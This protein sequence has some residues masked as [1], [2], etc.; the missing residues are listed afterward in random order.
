MK[1]LA[2]G[3]HVIENKRTIQSILYTH[4]MTPK[5]KDLNLQIHQI[6]RLLL[7]QHNAHCIKVLRNSKLDR[8]AQPSYNCLAMIGHV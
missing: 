3:A 1:L 4:I 2:F 6:H 5:T 7:L 8:P